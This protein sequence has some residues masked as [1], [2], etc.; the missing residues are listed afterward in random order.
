MTPKQKI[1]I[2]FR[3][4][5]GEI[6]AVFL[7]E[8]WTDDY[9]LTTYARIGQHGGG[10]IDWLYFDT[11]PA[12]KIEYLPLLRE[13]KEIYSDCDLIVKNKLPPYSTT[14]KVFKK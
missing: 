7:N 8:K 1:E 5:K 3:K 11:K 4:N 14:V 13:L 6:S 9:M 2:V 10:H 12:K